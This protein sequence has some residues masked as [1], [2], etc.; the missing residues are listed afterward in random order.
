L[1]DWAATVLSA[2]LEPVTGLMPRPQ[3]RASLDRLADEVGA[4][5]HF[6]LTALHDLVTLSGSLIIGLSVVHGTRSSDAAW[7]LSRID[8]DYQAEQWGDDEEALSV[9]EDRRL[10]FEHSAFLLGLC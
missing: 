9:A 3:P 5:D 1:I 7:T 8:E 2:P 6:R 4:L 10:A